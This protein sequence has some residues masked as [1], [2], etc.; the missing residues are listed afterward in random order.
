[1]NF[2]LKG[3]QQAFIGALCALVLVFSSL[4]VFADGID[5]VEEQTLDLQSQLAEIDQELLDLSEEIYATEKLIEQTNGAIIRSEHSLAEAELNRDNQ[6]DS[7]A[8]RIRFIYEGGN[9]SLIEALLSAESIA[10]FLNKAE[11]IQAMG[12]LDREM[13]IAL[14]ETLDTVELH[15]E[16]LLFQQNALLEIKDELEEKQ[17]ELIALAEE[18]A[19][20]LEVLLGLLD[21]LRTEEALRL[22][23]EAER[24]AAEIAAAT[25]PTPPANDPPTTGNTG[26][27][28]G[29][30][31]N[32][33]GGGGGGNQPPVSVPADDVTLFAALLEAEAFQNYD[34]L[35]A[36]ASAVMGRVADPR[37]PGTLRDVIFQPGQFGPVTNGSLDRILSRGPTA[38]SIQVAND[39]LGGARHPQL[40]PAHVFFNHA[41]AS[42]EPGINIGGNVFWTFWPNW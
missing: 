3:R 24:V 23:A 29:T 27:N 16:D 30:N 11:F 10:D 36:V 31:N 12:S 9:V 26:N 39:A 28:S 32:S 18:T 17:E 38:L 34:Y 20:D 33:G 14:Q 40:T 22:Q 37:F 42:S 15:R 4:T 21:Q 41:G 5:D 25:P 2:R 7:M 8:M 13:L 35:L 6:Q 19:T 1:M